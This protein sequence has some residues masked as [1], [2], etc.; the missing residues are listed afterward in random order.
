MSK[1]TEA[2]MEKLGG[3]TPK[4]GLNELMYKSNNTL[5]QMEQNIVIKKIKM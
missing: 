2:V 1:G 4:I 3:S 5:F